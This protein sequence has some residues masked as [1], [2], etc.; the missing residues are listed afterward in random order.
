MLRE[1]NAAGA[2]VLRAGH[3]GGHGPGREPL[4]GSPLAQVKMGPRRLW[5]QVWSGEMLLRAACGVW[6]LG[7]GRS[8]GPGDGTADH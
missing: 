2:G 4:P 6:E 7:K 1:E 5:R 3:H 8:Q